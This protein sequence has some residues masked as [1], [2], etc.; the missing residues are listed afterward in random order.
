[1]T[2]PVELDLPDPES[3]VAFGRRLG[4]ILRAGD[5]VVLSGELGAGK[6]T[7]T[8]G[9]G[10]GLGVRG[11]VTSPTFVIAR[12]H[13]SLLGGPA[14]LHVDAYRVASADEIDDLDL[15]DEEAVTVVEW[16]AGHIEHL[17]ESRIHLSLDVMGQGRRARV[18]AVGPRWQ[19]VDLA[20]E[21]SRDGA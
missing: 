7:L 4:G 21:L 17:A 8:R 19:G 18:E 2:A 11:P 6:T 3:T 10:E 9:I 12:R 13:P 16:G 1:M 14:L 5:L 15:I 20:V